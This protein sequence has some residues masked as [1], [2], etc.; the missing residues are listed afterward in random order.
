VTV[1]GAPLSVLHVIPALPVG[2][3]ETLVA[4]M[5]RGLDRRRFA[6][7]VCVLGEVGPVGEELLRAGIE[8]VA[9]EAFGTRG[10]LLRLVPRLARLYA[11]RQV[12]IVHTHLYHAN[13]YGRLAALLA[14][15]PVIV[16]SVHNVYDRVKWHRRLA[17]RWLGRRTDRVVAGSDRVRA[18]ILRWDGLPAARVAVVPYGIDLAPYQSPPPRAEARQALGLPAEGLII[19]TVGRLEIQKGHDIL[20]RGA[21]D[22]RREGVEARLVLVGDGRERGALERLAAGLGLGAAV[23]FL[24]TRRDLPLVLAALDL[25]AFP[26]RWEGTPL[27]LIAAMAAGLPVVATPVGGVPSVLTEGATGRMVPVEDVPA[28]TAAL[29]DLVRDPA[30]ARRLGGAGRAHVMAHCSATAMVRQLEALYLALAEQKGLGAPQGGR[31]T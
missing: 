1:G 16:A 17:N 25:F 20:L 24:G 31:P 10:R 7:A 11:E 27:A 2:G 14:R 9:L 29:R 3:A 6:P 30:A 19:G 26:S 12:Q 15:V 5:V 4:Q 22:L 18:D 8:V 13:Y 21:A 23:H 28:L